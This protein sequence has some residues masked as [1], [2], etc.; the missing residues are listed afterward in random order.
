MLLYEM[1]IGQVS[2]SSIEIYYLKPC[3]SLRSE[4]FHFFSEHVV[5]VCGRE[6]LVN[7]CS[8]NPPPFFD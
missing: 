8:L 7:S 1:L 2:F 4:L 3:I 6:Y 5:T